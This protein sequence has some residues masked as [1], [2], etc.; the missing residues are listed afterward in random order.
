[1]VPSEEEPQPA[2][3]DNQGDFPQ[4]S[5]LSR[6]ASENSILPS[7]PDAKLEGRV[8]KLKHRLGLHKPNLAHGNTN[9]K[10]DGEPIGWVLTVFLTAGEF[11]CAKA[12]HEI[13]WLRLQRISVRCCVIL[14]ER[15]C[16]RIRERPAGRRHGFEG[17]RQTLPVSGNNRDGPFRI[18]MA[19]AQQGGCHARKT[20]RNL[21][22]SISG[23]R[24]PAL[25]PG[26]HERR[27]GGACGMI[28]VCRRCAPADAAR[29]R[30][31][32]D[33]AFAMPAG[34]LV[35]ALPRVPPQGAFFIVRPADCSG[36][37][38]AMEPSGVGFLPVA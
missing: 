27:V 17:F 14:T 4:P 15:S 30:R 21:Q 2:A 36:A 28:G 35:P 7:Q 16:D 34:F 33:R 24:R 25:Q 6:T 26:E 20:V 19:S 1:M 23:N 13:R 10:N 9:T 3:I 5:F 31:S 38:A 22:T 12:A 18:R 32:T 11:A 29:S 8:W 37:V